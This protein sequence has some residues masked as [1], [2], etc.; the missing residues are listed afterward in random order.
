VYAAVVDIMNLSGAHFKTPTSFSIT[1]SKLL[2]STEA[3]VKNMELVTLPAFQQSI[4]NTITQGIAEQKQTIT[5]MMVGTGGRPSKV[6]LK[7]VW[8]A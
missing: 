3:S 8:L 4:S 2:D 5:D 7:A 6:M 1:E